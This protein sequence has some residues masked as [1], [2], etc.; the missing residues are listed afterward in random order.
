MREGWHV[1]RFGK[2]CKVKGCENP[3]PRRWYGEGRQP[4]YCSDECRQRGQ[5]ESNRQRQ[6]RFAQRR[7][8]RKARES[9]GRKDAATA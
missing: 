1:S 4:E 5:R 6:A 7:R 2:T 8:A 9:E 3:C